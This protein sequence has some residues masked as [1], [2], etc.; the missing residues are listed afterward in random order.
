MSSISAFQASALSLRTLTRGDALRACPWLLYSAPLA[1]SLP[2]APG[3]CWRNPLFHR[4]KQ[5]TVFQSGVNLD[6]FPVLYTGRVGSII[7]TRLGQHRCVRK[8]IGCSREV[9]PSSRTPGPLN[10]LRSR[11]VYSAIF[12]ICGREHRDPG[13]LQDARLPLPIVRR[14]FHVR[15]GSFH[16]TFRAVQ[17]DETKLLVQAV[18]VF[19]RQDP[20]TK[21][22]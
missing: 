22:L 8:S 4:T 1:L 6:F 18:C 20:T 5:E 13:S 16:P 21:S 19:G 14:L 11:E 3:N 12:H 7:T 2:L 15:I 9:P 17:L 10:T